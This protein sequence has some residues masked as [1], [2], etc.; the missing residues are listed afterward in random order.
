ME[1]ILLEDWIIDGCKVGIEIGGGVK[2]SNFQ[3]KNT[4]FSATSGQDST[5]IR[6]SGEGETLELQRMM[7]DHVILNGFSR[8]LK[9]DN[10][11][12]IRDHVR[13]VDSDFA[14]AKNELNIPPGKVRI[15][16]M[17]WSEPES[18]I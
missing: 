3:L 14:G 16:G 17:D 8:G 2:C 5:G 13:I 10:D 9:I 11:V 18:G 1:N 7:F 12:V 15:D 6:L 4:V